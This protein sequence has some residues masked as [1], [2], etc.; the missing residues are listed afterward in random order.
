MSW[1]AWTDTWQVTLRKP[2][3]TFPPGPGMDIRG[4]GRNDYGQVNPA[5]YEP[6]LQDTDTVIFKNVRKVST[7][8]N[9]TLVLDWEGRVFGWG[10]NSYG[11]IEPSLKDTVPVWRDKTYV[12]KTNIKDI[13]AGGAHSLAISNNNWASAWGDNGSSQCN[14]YGSGFK[15]VFARYRA[16]LGITTSNE[17]QSVGYNKYGAID[18]DSPVV[19]YPY[20]KSYVSRAGL[21][22]GPTISL[23]PDIRFFVTRSFKAY[24]GGDNDYHFQ[25]NPYT[26]TY[27]EAFAQRH[28]GAHWAYK[29]KGAQKVTTGLETRFLSLKG[30]VHNWG[31]G[32]NT[33]STAVYNWG[34][35]YAYLNGWH[36]TGPEV[37]NNIIAEG[38][39]NIYE[40]KLA[41][42]ALTHDRN[43]LAWGY[44]ENASVSPIHAVDRTIPL[45][46]VIIATN[47]KYCSEGVGDHT[48]IA[49]R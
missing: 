3:I 2:I 46:G 28:S 39:I 8:L 21:N 7:G 36:T 22:C 37:L 19:S 31:R 33:S 24:S 5:S 9:H 27:A 34:V 10:D 4:F 1:L 44:N 23:G 26:N 12:L 43:L 40:G 13:A 35:G 38:I 14:L 18:P 30:Q 48:F 17:I 11:Q 16:S 41:V 45:D 15:A 29:F 49:F 42:F 32:V 6:Y 47:V 20:I 25:S